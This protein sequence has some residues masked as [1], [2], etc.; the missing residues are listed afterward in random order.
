MDFKYYPYIG[1]IIEACPKRLF[2]GNILRIRIKANDFS[3][4]I[5][6]KEVSFIGEYFLQNEFVLN[7]DGKREIEIDLNRIDT[8]TKLSGLHSGY[9]LIEYNPI[10]NHKE[11]TGSGFKF[12]KF[13]KLSLKR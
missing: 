6:G 3:A 13:K 9:I 5:D 2:I 7:F 12:V 4:H 1:S 10:N 8:V 11:L